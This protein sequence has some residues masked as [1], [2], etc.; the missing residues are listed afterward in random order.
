MKTIVILSSEPWGKVML[1][2]MHFAHEL[3]EQNNRVFFI[4][5]PR[6]LVEKKDGFKPIKINGEKHL[7]LIQVPEHPL[8]VFGREKFYPL[9]Y[10]LEKKIIKAI[11][12]ITG[13]IDELWNF[14][15]HFITDSN[16]FEAKKNLLFLYDLYRGKN[17]IKAASC[18]D[19]IVSV[20]QNILNTIQAAQKPTL[21]LNHGLSG[22]FEKFA[23]KNVGG[24]K[25]GKR[26]QI[27]YVGNLLRGAIDFD[28]FRQ[29]IS[30]HPN[31]DFHIWGPSG[32]KENNVSGADIS[33]EAKEFS[34]FLH[35]SG[36]V[37]LHGVMVPDDLAR[38]IQSMDGFLFLYDRNKDMNQASN[39]HKLIEYLSTGKPV[40]SL[41]VSSY[42][43][44][45]L[46]VMQD[47]E[48]T[49]GFPDFFSTKVGNIS[50]FTEP[51]MVSRRI[52]FALENT[53]NKQISR[54]RQFNDS[55]LNE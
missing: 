34:D 48:D 13:N 18:A 3:S 21:L 10:R 20:A 27:G 51:A 31:I 9:Y 37:T 30:K 6:K 55:L 23:I 7:N 54:I 11:K 46:L 32:L 22:S 2:K 19:G 38:E 8:R 44:K 33:S 29:I 49:T 16:L 1:S 42:K 40:F 35:Q 17:I 52:N 26:V 41:F 4:Q 25:Q 12:E 39:S 14:N 53:Y 15:P 45:D 24:H 47:E 36:N 43:G 28:A 5:P 50:A